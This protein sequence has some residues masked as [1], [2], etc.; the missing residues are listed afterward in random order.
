MR[1]R[2]LLPSRLVAKQAAIS[3]PPPR[4]LLEI[5]RRR[6]A[7]GSEAVQAALWKLL[8][9]Q[10]TL[11]LL[12][13]A[14][15]SSI[16]DLPRFP[17]TLGQ[18][19]LEGTALNESV[20]QLLRAFTH[21]SPGALTHLSLPVDL[22]AEPYTTPDLSRF[23]NLQQLRFLLETNPPRNK[24]DSP[25]RARCGDLFESIPPSVQSVTLV[26]RGNV[27]RIVTLDRLPSTIVFLN[28]RTIP[29]SPATLPAFVRSP[30]AK[31]RQIHYFDGDEENADDDESG[32]NDVSR[33]G[34]ASL[35][36][37]LE[38]SGN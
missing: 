24:V 10:D 12:S 20:L 34:V 38:I 4:L 28:T 17:F 16:G 15:D 30:S 22:F 1:R 26:G 36:G 18:L 13:L 35:L 2:I 21:R 19:H 8:E 3:R 6:R 5:S 27:P 9:E 23:S 37:N 33:R 14:L 11:K 25:D 7:P 32:W 31:V 29:F